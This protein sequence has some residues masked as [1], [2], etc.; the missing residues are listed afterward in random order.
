[1]KILLVEDE[2]YIARPIEQLLKKN[3]FSVDVAHDGE[4]G[5]D[6][7]LTGIYDTIILDILMPK[8]DGIEVLKSLRENGITT[9]VLL[10]T[11]KDQPKDKVGGLDSGADDYLAKPFDNEELL[12]RLR[13][14]GR[15]QKDAFLQ[16]GLRNYGDI[17]FNPHTLTLSC[18][19]R[20]VKLSPKESQLLEMLIQ[21]GARPVS[22]ERIIEKV[23]GY[24]SNAEHNHVEYH[25]S[26]LRKKL[27]ETQADVRIQVT[28]NVG[29][30]LKVVAHEV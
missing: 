14:L 24:D 3:H 29:Y 1:M 9:P 21:H 10:L 25:I 15:R 19:E 5:L 16:G 2:I 20:S 11:A 17:S 13:A 12:A 23:W 26:L 7:G 6:C 27:A 22:K 30:S 18:K 4:Y 28:R 8:M